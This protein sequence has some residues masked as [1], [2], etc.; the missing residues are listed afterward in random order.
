MRAVC[1]RGAAQKQQQKHGQHHAGCV[2]EQAF[3]A[4]LHGETSASVF[5]PL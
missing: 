4:T 5:T 2:Q 3:F 1:R